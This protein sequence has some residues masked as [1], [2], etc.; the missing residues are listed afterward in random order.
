M[1]NIL[2]SLKVVAATRPTHLSPVAKRRN[3]LAARIDQQILVAQAFSRGEQFIATITRR[4]RNAVTG[5]MM[6][7]VRQRRVKECWWVTDD[8]KLVLQ[9]RY[10]LRSIEFSKG[11]SAIEVGAMDKLIPTLEVLKTATLSGELDEQL[12]VTAGRLERQLKTKRTS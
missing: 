4:N 10:G 8:G 11:K 2:Q 7:S 12:S 3:V 9:L 6:E 1:P 5:E